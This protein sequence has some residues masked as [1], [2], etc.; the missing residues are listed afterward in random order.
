MAKVKQA[1]PES[2]ALGILMRYKQSMVGDTKAVQERLAD[3]RFIAAAQKLLKVM[4]EQEV[5]V[6]L[7]APCLCLDCQESVRRPPRIEMTNA[8]VSFRHLLKDIENHCEIASR[9]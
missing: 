7:L 5:M 3:E 4:P 9:M 6:W 8:E 2:V 1:A